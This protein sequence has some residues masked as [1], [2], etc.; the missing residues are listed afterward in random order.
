MT[1]FTRLEP[2][3]VNNTA[4]FTFANANITGNLNVSGTTNVSGNLAA[5][6]FFGNGSLLSGM[7]LCYTDA[8]V[9]AYLPMYT[10]N[11]KA[12]NANLGDAV[13]ATSITAT[14]IT[15]DFFY[16][17]IVGGTVSNSAAT[18][19]TVTV[20]AQPNITSVGTLT[21]LVVSGLITATGTGVKVGN[22]QDSSGTVTLVTKYGNNSG[23]V[24]VT[25]NLTLGISGSGNLIA[26]NASLTGVTTNNITASGIVNFANTSNVTL[27]SLSNLRITGGLTDQTIFSS[28]NGALFWDTV[29]YLVKGNSN[30]AI[31]ANGNIIMSSAGNASIITVTGTGVNVAGTMTATGN[32]TGSNLITGGLVNATGNVSGNN[33]VATA[34]VSGGNLVTGGIVSATG[35]VSGGNLTTA[36]IVT[37]TSV[38]T[39]G[40]G[41]VA[42]S[43]VSA[44]GIGSDANLI[45]RP[46]SASNL[47]L[48]YFN[49]TAWVDRILIDTTGTTTVSGLMNTSVKRF[50]ETVLASANTGTSISPDLSTG[51]I[52]RYTANSNFTFNGFTN[53]V[54]GASAT[55]IITQDAT[56]S[57]LLTS[58]MK[59][60][61][62][63]KTLSTAANSI[64][65]ITVIYDGTTYFAS[66]NKGFA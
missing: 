11:L 59:F 50:N 20:N 31:M 9:A 10:G 6:Y 13:T 35:N 16:G 34:N 63:G 62:G 24:G 47:S 64:D 66:L 45:L 26:T 1:S 28:G 49:G 32:I 40:L 18:A 4:T 12:G 39:S 15:A 3:G 65:M 58:T 57:R 55:V 46:G 21:G 53:P 30:I 38:Y 42:A 5:N 33:I 48:Q 25:G 43:M 29:S 2:S 54:A 27:G 41:L 61:G 14:S 60:V 36:G 19:G 8:N 17:N 44:H 51:T 52:F 7:N 37:S 23:D 22:I 56:G